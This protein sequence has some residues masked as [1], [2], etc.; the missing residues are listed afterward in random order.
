MID[1][2]G[3]AVLVTAGTAAVVSL[4]NLYRIGHV[5][6]VAEESLSIS[7][8]TE[9]NT[10]SMSERLERAAHEAGKLQGGEDERA[11]AA[12]LAGA[13]AQGHADEKASPS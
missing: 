13:L 4:V 11:K 10:N 7:K 12:S 8:K 5:K 1:W 9:L 6:A 2:S 3:M